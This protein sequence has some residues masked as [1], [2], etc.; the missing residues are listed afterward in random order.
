MLGLGQLGI[1]QGQFGLQQQGQEYNQLAGLLG[2]TQAPSAGGDLS[3]FYGP[4]PIDM[5]NAYGMS[6]QGQMY[7]AGN[8]ITGQGLM[9]GLFGL[10]GNFLQGGG[11]W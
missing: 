5:M 8:Q 6:N 11:W 4:S 7:N 10:G 9:A 1:Q 3:S 2:L